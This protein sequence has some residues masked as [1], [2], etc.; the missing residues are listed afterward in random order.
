MEIEYTLLPEDL[1]AFAQYHRKV[2]GG[3]LPITLVDALVAV[4]ILALSG[5]LSLLL[6]GVF[7]SGGMFVGTII[8][9]FGAAF[10]ADWWQRCKTRSLFK[11]QCEDQHSSWAVR[12]VRAV[13]SPDQLRIIARGVTASYHWFVVWH[14]GLTR[15][16]VFLCITRVNAITIPRRAFRDTAHCEEFVALARQYQQD[17]R[18][19]KPKPTGIITSLPPEPTA[20]RRSDI[21]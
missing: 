8:G 16:H 21:P 7:D 2:P 1:Q 14:I 11:T 19:Q 12:D 20:I 10:F 17:C 4:V 18:E 6:A 5:G 13:I 3:Q 15:K 9:W